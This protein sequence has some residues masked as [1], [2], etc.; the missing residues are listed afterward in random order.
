MKECH[1]CGA[2]VPDDGIFCPDCGSRA[3]GK[4]ECPGCGKLIDES[5][6][7]CTYCGKRTD[8]KTKCPICGELADG[9]FCPN[10]GSPIVKRPAR[11]SVET[12]YGSYDR[13]DEN[14]EPR[15]KTE[16]KGFSL[17]GKI[18][19]VVSP[20][21]MLTA[22]LIAFV[23]SFFVGVRLY[24]AS[25][26][27]LP[28]TYLV[29][30]NI[31][32]TYFFGD[33]YKSLKS[34]FAKPVPGIPGPILTQYIVTTMAVAAGIITSFVLLVVASVKFGKNLRKKKY[35]NL[36]SHAAWSTG[37]VTLASASIYCQFGSAAVA[38]SGS[39]TVSA[40]IALNGASL[41]AIIL[42]L[43]L[44]V[45]AIAVKRVACGKKALSL[46]VLGK[47]ICG[48]V[49]T[50]FALISLIV[51]AGELLGVTEIADGYDLGLKISAG[52]FNYALYLTYYVW[53]N[54]VDN[55][56]ISALNS[57]AR[58]PDPT[59]T[60]AFAT[61]MALIVALSITIALAIIAAGKKK[62]AAGMLTGS[63]VS[64]CAAIA[65][66]VISILLKNHLLDLDNYASSAQTTITLS[67]AP[68]IVALVLTT[69]MLAISITALVFQS[70]RKRD[71][72]CENA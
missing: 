52:L 46:A 28:S 24:S 69:I 3:D 26:S 40:S 62:S 29:G 35:V 32:A 19:N 50:I 56:T 57:I 8:G 1:K 47:A 25:D 48:M 68:S 36:T 44:I 17:Y 27:G 15:V 18:A 31:S 63:I 10:C 4:K 39:K 59:T 14:D 51:V 23:C 42:P 65:H 21:L 41:T 30:E 60:I 70:R 72:S 20:A 61:T 12:Q 9:D 67:I 71:C 34:A 37:I 45:A 55:D 66:L 13:E 33:C 49:A 6:I 22:T 2:A 53:W 58:K 43:L 16:S 11:N 38:A 7:Y 5:A 64:F 54:S